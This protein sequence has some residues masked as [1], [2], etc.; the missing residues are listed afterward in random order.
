MIE[1]F[2]PPCLFVWS[3]A[4]YWF[5]RTYLQPGIDLKDVFLF[6]CLYPQIP[7]QI[8][9]LP[10]FQLVEGRLNAFLCLVLLFFLFASVLMFFAY[11]A[12]LFKM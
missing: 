5:W 12:S 6:F 7:S 4:R 11:F 8:I 10:P 2:F 9:L 3:G 1:L